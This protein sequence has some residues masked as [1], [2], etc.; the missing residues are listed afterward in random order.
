MITDQELLAL[1]GQKDVQLYEAHKANQEMAAV[2]KAAKAELEQ[3]PAA[4]ASQPDEPA[5][6]EAG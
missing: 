3:R 1:L 5:P 6:P 4:M 2:L